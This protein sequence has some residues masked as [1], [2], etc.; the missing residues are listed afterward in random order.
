[1]NGRGGRVGQGGKCHGGMV[2][3]ELE[4]AGLDEAATLYVIV[5]RERIWWTM[6]DER[7][8]NTPCIF[9]ETETLSYF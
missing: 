4:N 8:I 6:N 3:V 1:M 2:T 5:R 9:N 7:L